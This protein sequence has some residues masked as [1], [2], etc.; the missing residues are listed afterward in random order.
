MF[1]CTRLY[2]NISTA[3]KKAWLL[4]LC[5]I[6]CTT[7]ALAAPQYNVNGS[8]ADITLRIDETT[9]Y[10]IDNQN[11]RLQI[12]FSKPFAREFENIDL[13]LKDFIDQKIISA[14]GKNL[15]LELSSPITVRNNVENGILTINIDKL[16]EEKAP[17]LN[18]QDGDIRLTYGIHDAFVR[19][20]FEYV[21]KPVYSLN[22]EE[23]R[24]IISFLS[25]VTIKTINLKEYPKSGKITKQANKAGGTDIV[26]PERLLSSSEFKNKLVFDME[27]AP[28]A[29]PRTPIVSESSAKVSKKTTLANAQEDIGQKNQ[30]ASLSFPWN[31]PV[32]IAVFERNGYIWV[33][34]DHNQKVNLEE[35]AKTSSK[36]SDEVIQIP[37]NKATVLRFKP[38]EKVKVGLRKEGLLWIVDLYTHD[39]SYNIREL[40]IFTQ[41]NSISQAYLY[42]PTTNAGTVVSVIDPEI[43]DI[44]LTA[45]NIELGVGIDHDYQYPDF[46]ILHAKQGLAIVPN[47]ND[48]VL[49][50]G[51]TGLS[52]KGYDRGLNISED[53]ENIK[54][55]QQLAAGDGLQNFDFFVSPQLL[56]MTFNDAEDLL[57]KDISETTDDKKTAA[58]MEL[59]KY[60]ISQG[61][62][63][64]AL[65]I[66]EKI[67]TSTEPAA[68]SEKL[69]ALLGAA[70]FLA[71]RY[72]QAIENF[73]YGKLPNY[74]EAVFWRTLASTAQEFKKEDNVVLFSFMSVMKDY[75]QELKERIS[76]IASAAAINA[77]D[78]LATQNFMD[79]LKST[80]GSDGRKAH[81]LY[82]NAQKFE[83]QGYPRNAVRE[84]ANIVYMRSQKYSS[85]ARFA[86]TNLELKLNVISNDKAIRE[87]ER[88]RFAWGE[89]GFKVQLL[90]KLAATYAV[91]KDYYN[92]LRTY[93]EAQDL[94]NAD[95]KEE[96]GN[97]MVKLF[98]DVYVNN[99]ADNMA[100]LKALA[101]YQDFEWL[102]PKSNSYGEII[103]NL[104]DRLVAVDLL[105][106]A[107]DLLRNQLR[108]TD[109]DSLQRSK[110]GAR[111]AL[112]YLFQEDNVEALNVLDKT[113]MDETPE[114]DLS[115]RRIIR[116]KALANLK[117]DDEAIALLE[118][119]YS[120][121]AMLLKSDIYWKQGAW[122]KTA[123]TLKYLIEKP[124]K[125]KPLTDEQIGYILDW[126]TAL[127]KAGR[128]TVIIRLRNKFLPYFQNTAYVSAFNMLTSNLEK[129]KIDIKSINRAIN[130]ISAYSN[131]SK[132]YNQALR[133][134]KTETA[135]TGQ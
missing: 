3:L 65:K 67:K 91:N 75:S 119:D 29:A 87:Y 109:L 60:Y 82:L 73:S 7:S 14:D 97:N 133:P 85:L 59:A 6:F 19:F 93:K 76:L 49:A 47:A 51:N 40:P 35:I 9:D 33:V 126:A 43:G 71:K 69:Y 84:Y 74:N 63:T 125:N 66:L 56:Q 77:S 98:E 105:N 17:N 53:L 88:L 39:I 115:H 18:N 121:N 25:P 86:K 52:I 46:D 95:I 26:I 127:K 131:F 110:I 13:K 4:L 48:I 64:N 81:I 55:Q 1:K 24:T 79:V 41:Y 31:V 34:F 130:D 70:N 83:L 45:P 5:L 8:S 58:K 108:R 124:V 36:V 122:D 102:A 57:K 101:M 129:D 68:K 99:L 11:S 28:E 112:V 38:K 113:E 78:D 42:I 123:D 12:S 15:T 61:L 27:K 30:V 111:L 103:Q 80:T 94:A 54:R 32:G 62:G 20:V 90:Q 21:Q 114:T 104:A 89:S 134:Q 106:R 107:S 10:K 22:S 37:H 2:F 120:K 135:A 44:I 23:E 117:N 128:E 50:R 96:I 92:A 118:D 72:N 116:A 100:P 132:I 16:L